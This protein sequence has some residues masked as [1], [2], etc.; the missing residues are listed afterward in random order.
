[1]I[2]E[3]PFEQTD[4]SKGIT[5]FFIDPDDVRF[6]ETMDNLFINN[7]KKPRT[8]WGSE[9]YRDEQLPLGNFRVNKI[10]FYQQS[11]I[12]ACQDKRIYRDNAGWTEITGPAG[13]ALFQVGGA[14]SQIY[15]TQWQNH[16]YFTNDSLN[17]V[18][19]LYKDD[20]GIFQV[21]NAGLPG[22]PSGVSIVNPP[23][24]GSVYLYAFVLRYDYNVDDVKYVDRGPVYVYPSQVTGGTITG[25]N[26]AA[27]TLPTTLPIVENW[28]QSNIEVEIYRTIDAGTTYY[29][30]AKVTLG[31]TPY[32][33]EI[34][35]AVIASNEVLYTDGGV[36][37]ND[38][39]PK[40]K[41]MHVVNNVGY[42]GYMEDGTDTKKSLV[43]QSI[44]GDPDSV[45][46]SF[47]QEAEQELKGL[48]SIFDRPLV[49]CTEYVYR[50][51]GVIDSTGTGDFVLA[52]IDDIAGCI[53]Q[54]SIVRTHKGIFWAGNVGF[55]WSDGFNV[56]MINNHLSSS[57]K[58]FISNSTRKDRIVGAYDPTEDR[59]FWTLSKNS[60]TDECDL[61]YSLD[62]NWGITEE[63][64]FTTISG[65]TYFS[66]SY[67]AFNKDILYRADSRGFILQHYDGL[68]TDIKVDVLVSPADWDTVTII[69][70]YESCFI[71]FGSKFMRKWVP[72]M[73]VSAAN[74]TNLS[75]AIH[76]SNDNNRVIGDLRPIR[77]RD[78]I[79][80][81]DSLPLW[82]DTE[83]RWNYQGIIEEKRRF[84]SGGL[85]CQ[86]KQIQL[87]NAKVQIVTSELLGVVS[88]D[89][90]LKTATLGGTL[91]WIPALI[92]Y[93]IA[94]ESDDYTNE[95]VITASTTTTLT[96]SDPSNTSPASG[97]YKWVMRGKPKGEVLEL[98][99]YVLFWSY[100]S[101]SHTPFSTSS[102]GS[103]P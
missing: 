30:V 98:N 53:S 82:G 71:D 48:S 42:Y 99:G 76:S 27:I 64:T 37:D 29:F 26:A 39:P 92:D 81:G 24:A 97:T 3:K 18:Q 46:A 38:T 72:G 12:L 19:K 6:A 102:L 67:I 59:V 28:D 35:D 22:V 93:V 16:F 21:R 79:T 7:N 69:H 47:F 89:A 78:N 2:D 54:N 57:Y 17:S 60:G 32:N 61:L 13:G 73:L 85:R 84:P 83:A 45:P 68:L 103:N 51:D 95:Y 25:G 90:T 36:F 94:F 100:I 1:M 86:Y 58:N 96:F 5:D 20:G 34:T 91:Q 15:H 80:W 77:Y 11:E 70:D 50:I 41:F 33:D 63:S 101:K 88:V 14:N 74:T 65:S 31:T 75:L 49:F 9:T 40:C 8:R 52:R 87:T 55:Y 44:P 10:L 4:F 56:H 66:P 23:G 43:R 62:L